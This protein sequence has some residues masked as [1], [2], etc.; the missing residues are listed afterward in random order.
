MELS[1]IEISDDKVKEISRFRIPTTKD[2]KTY[3]EK[4]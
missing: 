2:D 1:E 3:C 4:N